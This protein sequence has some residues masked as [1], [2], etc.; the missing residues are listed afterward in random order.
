MKRIAFISTTCALTIFCTLYWTV[1]ADS[2]S[3]LVPPSPVSLTNPD[4]QALDLEKYDLR[5]AVHGPLALTEMEMTFR[6]P[7]DRQMEGRFLYLLPPGA[8]V[9]RFAKEVNG[10]LMEGEVVERKRARRVYRQI[11]HTLRDPALLEQDQGNR[12]SARVFPIPAKATVR[13]LLS[14][15]QTISSESGLR[16]LIV[17]MAGMPS[18]SEFSMDVA[19]RPWPGER[20]EPNDSKGLTAKEENGL[21]HLTK[22]AQNHQPQKDL[23]VLFHTAKKGPKTR[24]LRAGG[25]QM[26]SY[27]P[28]IGS[29]KA[30]KNTK[31]DKDDWVFL[32]DTS[33]SNADTQARRL[34]AT[35]KILD[36]MKGHY[37]TLN[38]LAFDMEVEPLTTYTDPS[39][40]NNGTPKKIEW[41]LQRRHALGAT[42][43]AKALQFAGDLA[44]KDNKTQRFVLVSDGIATWGKR[45]VKDV[46]N[47]LGDWPE[48]DSL[49]VLV[50]GS[51]QDARM[52]SAIVGKTKG[53]IVTLNLGE[54]LDA[55]A[56]D[57]VDALRKPLGDSFEFYDE[58]AAWIHPKHVQDVQPNQ[59][60]I[61]FS[62]LKKDQEAKPG[63]VQTLSGNPTGKK[64]DVALDSIQPEEV[65]TFGPLLEREAC[66]AYLDH[67]AAQAQK[68]TEKEA[69]AKLRE[70]QIRVSVKNRVLCP[71]T[72]LL[73]LESEQDYDRFGLDRNALR[74]ILAIGPKGID[75]KKRT[76]KDLALKPSPK[77]TVRKS[78]KKGKAKELRA[79]K[80]DFEKASEL[81]QSLDESKSEQTAADLPL[82]IR[83][84]SVELGL[85]GFGGETAAEELPARERS[86]SG[87]RPQGAH[88]FNPASP[89]AAPTPE[90]NAEDQGRS[91]RREPARRTA[92]ATASRQNNRATPAKPKKPNWIKQFGTVPSEDIFEKMR[93]RISAKPRDRRLRNSYAEALVKAGKWDTL[94]ALG[95]EW[96]PFDPENPQI[97]EFLGQ[98]STQLKDAKSALRAYA[99]IAEVAPNRSGLLARAGWLMLVA[100][101]YELAEQMFRAALAQRED[102]PNIHRGLALSLWLGGWDKDASKLDAAAQVLEK[103]LKMKFNS[104][105]GDLHKVFKQELSYIYR[106]MLQPD[107]AA[108]GLEKRAR[109]YGVDLKYSDALRVTLCW[110]TDANDVDLHIVDPSGEECFYSH[111]KNASGLKLYS[112]QTQ[113]LGPEVIRTA[114][115][116]PGIYHVGVKYYNAGPMGVSRGVVVILRP[117][118]GEKRSKPRILPFCLVPDGQGIRHL[119]AVEF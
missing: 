90:Q 43:L 46:L 34:I 51:K 105:Y 57:A 109:Q 94:Q 67:L 115:T 74:D 56:Q 99:S 60:L 7:K 31:D 44:R 40:G 1:L 114:K 72:A 80:A 36:A 62:K 15:S 69:Q 54:G 4:G 12:F 97:F 81:P 66:R 11:L 63:V 52:L 35:S 102:N 5:V 116:L 49:H 10:K 71:L 50:L 9:S 82:E 18:I 8:T 107:S 53:R 98:S 101:R 112:D 39:Q 117:S 85:M 75:W 2:A 92:V 28:E 76:A 26:L 3:D 79:G 29:R 45:E 89:R 87:G 93:A 68:A 77:L 103:A 20:A 110:E 118:N 21:T 86:A 95:F 14:Y 111:K 6:N 61:V 47:A 24:I 70:Q 106:S 27:R 108:D 100:K 17:P 22:R 19:I 16:K 88:P 84:G 73:V 23:V 33:A 37:R 32:F 41:M 58:G 13:L 119:M 64:K 65:A 30:A 91:G 104:R 113:G 78:N 42:D 96:L 48:N 25:Y 83:D 38:A 55:K 59:E